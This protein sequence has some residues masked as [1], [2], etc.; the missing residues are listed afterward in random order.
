MVWCFSH[1][2]N[3][4]NLFKVIG[5]WLLYILTIMNI[6]K[7]HEAKLLDLMIFL[8]ILYCDNNECGCEFSRVI[9]R[10]IATC[11]TLDIY[12]MSVYRIYHPYPNIIQYM[13]L[14]KSH[15]ISSIS[16]AATSTK[17]VWFV[18]TCLHV[19]DTTP[20]SRP[21]YTSVIC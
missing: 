3:N 10:T 12:F 21:P 18:N 5:V 19:I 7:I 17:C 6:K 20:V 11:W 13:N 9:I 2:V 14:T 15:H 16:Y 4:K 8:V 1:C